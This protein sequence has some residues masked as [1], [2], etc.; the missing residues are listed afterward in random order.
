[1]FTLLRQ[2]SYQVVHHRSIQLFIPFIAIFQLA[3]AEYAHYQP[4]LLTPH[5]VFTNNDYGFIPILFLA[6]IIGSTYLTNER[7][8]GTLRALLYRNY[9]RTQVLVSKWLTIF[10]LIV[11]LY[12]FSTLVSLTLKFSLFKHLAN[13]GSIWLTWALNMLS[14]GLTLLFLMS[15]VL[16]LGTLFTSSTPAI[17]TGIIGYFIVTIFNQL[18]FYL[19]A[20]VSW[21]KWNPLN[22]INLG[23]QI[24][25]PRLQQLTGLD[26]PT[27]AIGYIIYLLFFLALA[28]YSFH[29]RNV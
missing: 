14:T 17:M 26:L 3:I 8:N 13:R 7:Q 23:D 15:I 16:L 12:G 4:Q 1:M 29:T 18:C 22:M 28:N 9:S 27:L 20:K 24:Q 5:D 19:Y 11:G 2:E 6:L 21:L 25:T 10:G